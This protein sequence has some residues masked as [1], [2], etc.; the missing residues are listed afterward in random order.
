MEYKEASNLRKK[1]IFGGITQGL[2]DKKGLGSSISDVFKAKAV[3]IK[4]KFD[5]MNIARMMGVNEM[6]VNPVPCR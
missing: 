3:G 6:V 2:V 4:E 1:G 5:P